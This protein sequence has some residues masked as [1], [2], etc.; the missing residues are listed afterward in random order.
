VVDT[1]GA[2]DVYHGA[3]LVGLLHGWD[4]RTVA[5]FSSAV[6]AIKCTQLSGRRGIPSFERT[7]AFLREHGIDVPF[8]PQ[9][10]EPGL[11]T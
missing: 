8:K 1:T 7:L 11:V 3:F 5:T 9:G 10:Q 2:G 6:A 4:L